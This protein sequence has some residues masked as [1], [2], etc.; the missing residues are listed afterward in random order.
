M[1]KDLRV[2]HTQWQQATCGV[3]T[4]VSDE[5]PF[6]EALLMLYYRRLLSQPLC[7]IYDDLLPIRQRL[8][9]RYNQI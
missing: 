9:T 6:S 4:T 1:V 5:I 8:A 7:R 2:G 3:W